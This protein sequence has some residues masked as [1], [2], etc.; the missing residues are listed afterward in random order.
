M[1]ALYEDLSERLES[2]DGSASKEEQEDVLE[3]L[4]ETHA[5]SAALKAFATV[6]TCL[7]FSL[8]PTPH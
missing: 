2:F 5:T 8:S 3:K 7:H 6:I 4:K 1:T